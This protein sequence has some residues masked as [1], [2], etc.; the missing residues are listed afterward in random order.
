MTGRVKKWLLGATLAGAAAMSAAAWCMGPGP[1]ADSDP[2]RMIARMSEQLDLSA[3][4]QEQVQSLLAA[5]KEEG[6]SDHR[7]MQELRSLVMAQREQFDPAQ[8]RQLADEIGTLTADMVYRA[9]ETWS[10]VYQLLTVEQQ[11]QLDELMA[12]HEEHRGK[13]RKMGSGAAAR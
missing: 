11:Q 13:W 8:T 10:Q 12:R 4:Q 7:R 6:A 9:S 2:T 1:G 3:A 5:S